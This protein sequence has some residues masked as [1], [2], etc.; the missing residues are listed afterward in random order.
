MLTHNIKQ[1]IFIV[2][3]NV[4]FSLFTLNL[5]ETSSRTFISKT[6]FQMSGRA[7]LTV[8]LTI[9]LFSSL[10]SFSMSEY[11]EIFQKKVPNEFLKCDKKVF[12]RCPEKRPKY[13]PVC[14]NKWNLNGNMRSHNRVFKSLGFDFVNASNGDEWDV[15]WGLEYPF[16]DDRS[17]LYDPLHQRPLKPHQRVNHFRGMHDVVC[18]DHLTIINQ[19]LE[20]ILPTFRFPKKKPEFL[21][22]I[23]ENPGKKFVEKNL[24]NRGVRIIDEK[25]VD[26][27]N[28]DKIYQLFMDKPFLIDGHAFDFG[29]F[30][31]I[32]S[33]DPLRV[34][35]YKT[36][37]LMRFCPEPYYPF[38]ATNTEKYVITESH[39]HFTRMNWFKNY[40]NIFGSSSVRGFEEYLKSK[41]YSVDQFWMT[42]D[43]AIVTIITRSVRNAIKEVRLTVCN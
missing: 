36:E 19:D 10:S 12:E 27:T 22:F 11:V 40:S 16:D 38:D 29:V 25:N 8:F 43:D 32:S 42:I 28:S 41:D 39:L 31:L 5:D 33:I 30:V 7:V 17:S 34:Y 14:V 26:F 2:D 13:W 9:K 37:V 23:E 4:I 24:G 21:K 18:K 3:S 20:F 35:R 1:P 15:L 6:T